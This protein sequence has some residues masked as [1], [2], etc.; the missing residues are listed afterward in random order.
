[1]K[2]KSKNNLKIIKYATIDLFSIMPSIVITKILL[3]VICSLIAIFN[4]QLLANIIDYAGRLIQDI[5]YKNLFVINILEYIICYIFIQL[6]SVLSYYIDNILI[7]PKMEYFHHKLSNHL[8][9]IS[10]EATHNPQTQNMFWRAKDAIYQDRIMSVFMTVFNIIPIIIQ[11]FGTM[12]VLYKYSVGL[13]WLAF[14][15]VF[16]SSI[17][18]FWI[19]K[20]E[21]NFSVEQTK[22]NRLYSYLW[23]VMTKKETIRENRIYGFL[24]YIKEVFF[25]VHKRALKARKNLLLKEDLG[26]S[27]AEILKNL[28]YIVALVFSINLV[29]NKSITVGMFAACLGVFTTMQTRASKLFSYFSQ[30]DN[31][32]QYANDYY[33]F[34]ELPKENS[35]NM[36]LTNSPDCIELKNICYKY[37]DDAKN[38]V[39]NV[40]INIK[41]GELIVIVGENGS[42]KT[43]LSK[44]LMGL[45]KPQCGDVWVNGIKE[46]EIVKSS[47]YE[48]FSMAIQNFERYAIALQDNVTISNIY[49]NIDNL[50]E[51]FYMC[52][53]T[54]IKEK[55]GGYDAMLGIEFGDAD[56]SG[57]E[58][59][60]IAL[61][62]SI[63]RNGEIVV[64]DEPTSAIDPLLEY[65]LLNKFLNIAKEKTCI[66]I[67]HRV[68]LCKK[69]DKIIVMNEGKVVEQGKHNELINKKGKYYE[70]WNAQ[71]QWYN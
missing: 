39:D 58:W 57:G 1:M 45:Y 71:A 16:P 13:V 21:Y 40:N 22:D 12:F 60:K 55:L 10:L 69:A 49:I 23:N 56:L 11:M 53:L 67:S 54:K 44:L 4:V 64:L 28:L 29:Y 63:Y 24:S 26:S 9:N 52:D 25:D 34:L 43:T 32:C 3:G 15:S 18:A 14:L 68:G 36:L 47:Y 61:A 30:I 46:S 8:T 41:K 66:I 59:Q 7:V 35:G 2:S 31:M 48:K 62:R 42:G 50:D 6:S 20:K 51:F 19:G 27:L 65:E 37:S 17:I 5:S 38:A 70:L 33:T